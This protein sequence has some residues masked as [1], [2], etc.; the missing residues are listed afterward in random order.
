MSQREKLL[1]DI[2]NNPKNRDYREI[3]A[4][5]RKYGFI[6][7]ESKGGGSH[8]PV[9]HPD[10]PELVWTLSRKKPMSTFHAKKAVKMVEEVINNGQE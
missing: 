3:V 4:L 10:F 1:D 5:F 6:V 7:N 2:K 9:Y 8:C